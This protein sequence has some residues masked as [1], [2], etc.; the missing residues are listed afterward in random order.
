MMLTDS[1]QHPWIQGYEPAYLQKLSS[2]DPI[3]IQRAGT[4][5]TVA[6]PEAAKKTGIAVD[7]SMAEPSIA[8]ISQGSSSSSSSTGVSN[9]PGAYPRKSSRDAPQRE[10]SQLVR[11]SDVVR[12]AAEAEA[13]LPVP[14]PEMVAREHHRRAKQVSPPAVDAD[15]DSDMADATVGSKRRTARGGSDDAPPRKRRSPRGNTPM[16]VDDGEEAV[17]PRRSTRIKK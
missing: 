17:A 14:T 8:Q 1:L 13:P 9:I 7:R 3:R 11:R 5:S 4:R 2:D 10:N 12:S 6:G 15:G 16:T